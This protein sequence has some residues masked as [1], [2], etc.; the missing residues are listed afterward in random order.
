M[1]F[2][3]N[4]VLVSNKLSLFQGAGED[5]AEYCLVDCNDGEFALMPTSSKMQYAY[6]TPKNRAFSEM[7]QLPNDMC[8]V[9]AKRS[10]NTENIF[11]DKSEKVRILDM[12]HNHLPIMVSREDVLPLTVCRTCISS[13]Q[14]ADKLVKTCVAADKTL[15]TL[16]EHVCKISLGGTDSYRV[17]ISILYC[18]LYP[19]LA[20]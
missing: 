12:I 9:C 11:S 14:I 17:S 18:G 20:F 1:H 15:R 7:W 8:R 10:D 6:E 5:L 3:F 2:F 13:L 4:I 19:F 16:L